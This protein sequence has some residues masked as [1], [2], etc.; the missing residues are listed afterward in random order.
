MFQQKTFIS[1]VLSGLL[2][3]LVAALISGVCFAALVFIGKFL[4]PIFDSWYNS[5]SEWNM[6]SNIIFIM[7][8]T[9]LFVLACW[10]T[11]EYIVPRYQKK[12]NS[13]K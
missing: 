4:M 2:F 11:G 3:L 1:T 12:T 10:S 7:L 6:F 13:V 5:T 9:I 8:I